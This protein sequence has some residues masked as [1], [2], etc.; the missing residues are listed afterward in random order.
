MRY[1]TLIILC[2]IQTLYTFGQFVPPVQYPWPNIAYAKYEP[3]QYSSRWVMNSS[4]MTRALEV[5]YTNFNYHLEGGDR[6]FRQIPALSVGMAFPVVMNQKYQRDE[7]LKYSRFLNRKYDFNGHATTYKGYQVCA[8]S[9]YDLL[10]WNFIS[11]SLAYGGSFGQRKLVSVIDGEKYKL[12]NPFVGVM[13]GA[14]LRFHITRYEGISFGGYCYYMHDISKPKWIN[15]GGYS[16]D[17]PAQGKFT[18]WQWGMGISFTINDSKSDE[19]YG[20]YY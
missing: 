18:G 19:S 15:R 9:E 14:D 16:Y 5:E 4:K 7:V 20:Y 17:L 2:S 11:L 1:V 8:M 3:T 12:R 13:G 6:T 10:G